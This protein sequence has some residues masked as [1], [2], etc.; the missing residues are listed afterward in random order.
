MK[1]DISSSGGSEPRS[2]LPKSAFR[3]RATSSLVAIMMGTLVLRTAA[4]AMG[5]NIQF[6]LNAIHQASLSPGHPLRLIAGAAHVYPISYTLGGVI[7]GS[8]FVAELLGSLVFGAWSDRLGR[9]VFLILGPLFGAIAVL[10]TSFTTVLWLLIFTR[11]LEGLSTASAVPATLGYLAEETSDSPGSRV[12]F[13]GFFEIATIGGIA[14]GFSLG[15]WLWRQLGTA[16]K[17]AGVTLTSPAFAANAAFYLLSLL[18][19]VWGI[20][21]MPG[22]APAA[23]GA[24]D[25]VRIVLRRYRTILGDRRVLEFAPAWIAINAVLG[26]W[27]NVTAR[28][29]TDHAAFPAQLLVGR[30]SSFQA[31]NVRA[32][33]ALLFIVGILAWSLLVPKIKRVTAM[34][35][36]VGGLLASCLLLFAI[37]HQTGWNAPPIIPLAAGLG[38]SIMVQSGFTPAA[39]AYLA[40][41]TEAYRGDRG[42]VMGLYSVFL[43]LG[44]FLG[45]ILGGIFVDW[46]GADGMALIAAWLGGFA[47][48][49]ILRLRNAE[50]SGPVAGR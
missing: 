35:I 8:F 13:A 31:G 11:L 18:I 40:D 7:I 22:P 14:V 27:I 48:L 17:V 6:Y 29:L 16:S 44:Q 34:L 28:M 20:R 45:A 24:A 9:K 46:R 23:A 41:L 42:A 3:K 2:A 36:G 49:L 43:G 4:S 39:L 38:L 47:A 19:F 25:S 30:F 10:V 26:I 1:T 50:S 37:N 33:Y 5:E 12:R 32:F 21:R 15:G